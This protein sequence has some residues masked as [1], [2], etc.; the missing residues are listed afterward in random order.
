MMEILNLSRML[1]TYFEIFRN[2]L[3]G[4]LL[5]Y[6]QLAIGIIFHLIGSLQL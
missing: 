3:Y 4:F 1:L 6:I 5:A 2:K